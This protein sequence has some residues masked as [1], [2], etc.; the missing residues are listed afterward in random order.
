M[1]GLT[2]QQSK[3]L[4][5]DKHISLTANAGSGKTRVLVERYL[6]AVRS[7][8]GVRQILCL[9]FTEKAALE[10]RQKIG[11]RIASEY[12]AARANRDASAALFGEARDKMLEA[13][14]NTIHSFCSQV[15]REFPVEAGIDANFK[16]L[17]DFDSSSLKEE[18]CTETV[19]ELLAHE[20]PQSSQG[21]ERR[22]HKLLVK[23]G[24][25]RVLRILADLLDNREKIEHARMTGGRTILDE[26]AVRK[27]WFNMARTVADVIRFNVSRTKGN[28][29]TELNALNDAIN[30]VPASLTPVLMELKNALDK[31]LTKKGTVRKK[32]IIL[33]GGAKYSSEDALAILQTAFAALDDVTDD[34]LSSGTEDYLRMLESLFGLYLKSEE[35][36]GRRKYLMGALDFDDLQILT[37]RLLTA[38]KTVRDTLVSRF[39]HVMVDEF[40]DTNFLQYGIFLNLL[41]NLASEARLFVVGDPKQ[42]I[43]R[44]RNAQV[45][46]SQ[47][48]SESLAKLNDGLSLPLSESFRMNSDIAAFV[49]DIFPEVLKANRVYGAAGIPSM[50]QTEYNALIPRRPAGAADPVEIFIKK[51][52]GAAGDNEEQDTDTVAEGEERGDLQALFTAARIRQMVDSREKI[53]S[54][55]EKEKE[56]EVG[57]AD[58]AVLLRTR[59]KL[60]LL[61][62]AMTM[63]GVPFV[64]SA[65]IGFYS[66]QEIFDLTNYLTFLL[67]NNADIPL[68]TVLRSPLF[69]I[70]EN[71]LY[72]ISQVAGTSLFE[73][74][75]GFAASGS[76]GEEVKYA[77]SVLSEEVGL[78]QRQTIPELINRILERTGWLG[79]YRLSSTADQRIANLRK[80]LAIAREFEGRGFNSLFDFVERIKY[81]KETAHEGQ[82]PVEE[83]ADAVKIMTVHAAKGL[84]FPVVFIPFC[85][86]GTR[87]DSGMIINDQVGILP[88]VG[89][90]VPPALSLYKRFE[91]MSEQAEMARLFYVA[92]TRAM[93]KLVLTTSTKK[94]ATSMSSFTDILVRSMNLSEVPGEEK[95]ELGKSKLRVFSSVPAVETPPE[96]KLPETVGMGNLFLG[97]IPANIDGEIYSATVLQTYRLCP[98]KYFLRYRLGMPAPGTS[99]WRPDNGDRKPGTG[100]RRQ[101]TGD[102]GVDSGLRSPD[103]SLRL[104]EY[105][106][107][108]L[109]T[110]KGQL[111]HSVLEHMIKTGESGEGAVEAAAKRAVS[112]GV[113]G[114]LSEEARSTLE[115]VVT[116]NARNALKTLAK[117]AGEG[118][119][120]TEQTIT[121]KFKSDYLTGTL[122]LLIEDEKG[123]HIYDYKTNRLDRSQ[124][125]IYAGYEI[126]MKLYASLCGNLKP[127][128]SE[129]D[130]TILFTREPGSYLRRDYSK[131]HLEEFEKELTD[132]LNGI[133][134]MEGEEGIFPS[135]DALPVVSP[136]CGECEY[137]VG[138]GRAKGCLLRRQ[139]VGSRKQDA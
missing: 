100:S 120:Y 63:Y 73:R 25:G 115:R 7:G 127:G 108:I 27:H 105:D 113:A 83:S 45:E 129:I 30:G 136:H 59:A 74:L 139:P 57:Y 49:N 35:I 97:S 121:R 81:L 119:R 20:R 6:S 76:A 29:D 2:E 137:F 90:D 51:R 19:R 38:E 17:E 62:N 92:C 84:E 66:A 37:L 42:S 70:S 118:K 68:L 133:K 11:E 138:E 41:D 86:S 102:K 112:A 54:V 87:R 122:D 24:Y 98:T 93:D 50:N 132:M 53:R 28:F 126:Q 23:V 134:G 1:A 88:F 47:V 128:Q 15:L 21:A 99:D 56:R 4:E 72:S 39:R 78:A 124:E 46:V 109:A 3:A 16:V 96:K 43:Y 95:I 104:D 80:L 89:D 8:A 85:D 48:A 52:S 110:V 69:G 12:H 77:A 31:I 130:V 71:E 117:I 106:D 5:L 131:T 32:D 91:T 44:F 79:A 36:Y 55:K 94:S 9:T 114:N 75:A 14:I 82:A 107:T 13:N 18:A 111:V 61:E 26:D 67:D 58:I 123:Y 103:S 60:Q 116:E 40:Q 22:V 10:L 101:E 65:G 64:V 34:S 135:A 125:E 33:E